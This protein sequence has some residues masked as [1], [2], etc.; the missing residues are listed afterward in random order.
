MKKNVLVTGAFGNIGSFV[1]PQLL[2]R[3]HQVVA[4]DIKTPITKKNS[5]KFAKLPIKVHWGDIADKQSL[6]SGIEGIDAVIHLAGIFPPASENNRQLAKSVNIDGTR[7]VIEVMEHSNSARRL[8][9]ASS[10]AVYGKEQGKIPPPLTVSHPLSPND[11]YGETK[12][13]C[14]AMIQ[15]SS[16]DWSLLR[17]SACPPA[18]IKNIASFKGAPFFENHPDAHIEV[19]HPAD[20]AL[21]FVNAVTCDNAIGKICLLGGGGQNR[22]NS[23]QL[24]NIMFAALGLKSLPRE[25]FQITEAIEFHGDWLDTDESQRLLQFQRYNIEKLYEDFIESLGLVKYMLILVKLFSPFIS[26]A[27]LKFSPYYEKQHKMEAV[28]GSF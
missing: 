5:R 24:F 28:P 27:I 21:A 26:R 22:I 12:A 18:N 15:A 20:S 13:E 1:I 9:F 2:S 10:I 4:L 19:V 23:L 11:Y 17:I 3:G 16:L 6:Q 8:V 14:E 25:A 7:N